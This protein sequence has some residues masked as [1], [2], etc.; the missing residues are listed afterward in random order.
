MK[1]CIF[2]VDFLYNSLWLQI[3]VFEESQQQ[4]PIRILTNLVRHAIIKE[5]A[6]SIAL[7]IRILTNIIRKCIRKERGASTAFPIR[8]PYEF[9]KEL[10]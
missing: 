7:L 10:Y 6:A 9:N 2:S 8:N 4:I 5:R 3:I 1:S